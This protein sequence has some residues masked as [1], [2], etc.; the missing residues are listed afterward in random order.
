MKVF[1]SVF[2]L[3]GAV[4]YAQAFHDE[5]SMLM[6]E[7]PL[8]KCGEQLKV[9][10]SPFKAGQKPD[11]AT[12]SQPQYKCLAKCI[13]EQF[14]LVDDSGKYLPEKLKESFPDIPDVVVGHVNDCIKETNEADLCDM[15]S[16]VQLCIIKKKM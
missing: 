14:G 8:K 4:L 10:I 2:C 5:A 9:D 16:K 12:I 6:M 1:L 11:L 3:F 13:M 15:Y 7:E